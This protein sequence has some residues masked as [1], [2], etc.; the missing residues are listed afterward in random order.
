MSAD[1]ENLAVA[2]KL[3]KVSFHFWVEGNSTCA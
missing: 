2:T 3:E 1:L